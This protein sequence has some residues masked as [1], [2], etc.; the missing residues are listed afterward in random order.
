MT[1]KRHG[2]KTSLYKTFQIRIFDNVKIRGIKK[3][4]YKG[5]IGNVAGKELNKYYIKM[6]KVYARTTGRDRTCDSIFV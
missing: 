5:F 1:L 3:V 2:M 6:L 4:S